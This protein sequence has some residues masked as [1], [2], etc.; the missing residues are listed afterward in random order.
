M[1][2]QRLLTSALAATR[3][4]LHRPAYGSLLRSSS[5]LSFQSNLLLPTGSTVRMASQN[6][7]STN[8]DQELSQFLQQDI[9]EERKMSKAPRNGPGVQGFDVS[10]KGADVILRRQVKGEEITIKFNVNGTVDG[11]TPDFDENSQAKPEDLTTEMRSLPDFLIQIRKPGQQASLVFSC[12]FLD[13][14]VEEAEEQDKADLFEIQN[15]FFLENGATIESEFNDSVYMA[16]GQLIDGQLYDL[17]MDY[18]DERGI[19]VEFGEHLIEY[20]TF[21]EHSQYVGLLEKFNKF[22]ESK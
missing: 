21:H 18:L 5:A 15:F 17:L 3:Q 11:E 10:T 8:A 19:G 20:A 14:Q 4:Q 2:S 13:G 7:Y 1:L 12:V 16:D 22:I 9:K 6:N